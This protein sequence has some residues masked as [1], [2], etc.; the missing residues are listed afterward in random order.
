M[1]LK[2]VGAPEQIESAKQL[3]SE[4]IRKSISGDGGYSSQQGCYR[5]QS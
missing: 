3:I 2:I 5:Q 4:I 1:T